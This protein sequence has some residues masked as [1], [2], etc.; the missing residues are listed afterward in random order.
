MLLLQGTR[1]RNRSGRRDADDSSPSIPTHP[2]HGAQ[3]RLGPPV[4]KAEGHRS[5]SRSWNRIRRFHS[6]PS[7]LLVVRRLAVGGTGRHR[8]R[9][10]RGRALLPALGTTKGKQ[11][12]NV[13]RS[14]ESMRLQ[15]RLLFELRVSCF[16]R[17]AFAAGWVGH[18]SADAG[19]PTTA[20]TTSGSSSAGRYRPPPPPQP[21]P[22]PAGNPS[23]IH[24]N[25]LPSPVHSLE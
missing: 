7:S 17:E 3:E 14:T 22:Q 23:D 12:T 11:H 19:P 8:R 6:R 18:G 5:R 1:R 2:R 15:A 25:V 4:R 21:A 13:F 20:A 9:S 24:F 16:G 10:R